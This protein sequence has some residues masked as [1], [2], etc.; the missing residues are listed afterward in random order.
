MMWPVWEPPVWYFTPLVTINLAEDWKQLNFPIESVDKISYL[1]TLTQA[2]I[3]PVH[4]A[5]L[6]TRQNHDA[7]PRG[8][9][10]LHL[11][12]VFDKKIH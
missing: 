5:F 9:D 1:Y 11:A 6:L 2:R 4:L 12:R 8:P 3:I 10:K 7:L